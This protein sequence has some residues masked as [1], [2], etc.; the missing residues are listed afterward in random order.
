MQGLFLKLRTVLNAIL[1][2]E[3]GQDLPEYALTF[4]VIAL[5]TVAGMSSIANGV[6][7][8]FTVV[9]NVLTNAV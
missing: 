7:L 5:G 3:A 2:L 6:N 1:V 9:A 8:T 4:T